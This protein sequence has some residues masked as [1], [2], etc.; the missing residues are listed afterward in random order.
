VEGIKV[1]MPEEQEDE[2]KEI[3]LH[4]RYPARKAQY[5]N[6]VFNELTKHG[7]LVAWATVK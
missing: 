7:I 5:L 3:D 4:L 6:T 1:E 2:M